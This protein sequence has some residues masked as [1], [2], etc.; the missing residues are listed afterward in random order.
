MSRT[1]NRTEYPS[2][3]IQHLRE[4]SEKSFENKRAV[5]DKPFQENMLISKENIIFETAAVQS[6]G[7][8]S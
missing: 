8:G 6:Y 4:F 3:L 1:S 5:I 2:N 7:Y